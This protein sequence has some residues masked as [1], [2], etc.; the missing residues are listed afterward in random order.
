[1]S[2]THLICLKTNSYQ[3]AR[4]LYLEESFYMTS[5][6]YEINSLSTL[7]SLADFFLPSLMGISKFY[8]HTF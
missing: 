8:S 3:E 4:G 7:K 1:M 5:S 2:R 6:C